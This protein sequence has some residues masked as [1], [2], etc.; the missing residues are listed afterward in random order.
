M[1]RRLSLGASILGERHGEDLYT[2]ATAVRARLLRELAATF[3]DVDVLVSPA[4]LTT[5][6]LLGTQPPP[7]PAAPGDSAFVRAVVPSLPANYRDDEFT[8]F[9]SLVRPPPSSS[10][11]HP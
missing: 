1:R 6:R 8:C 7:S 10:L 2:R 5:A 4:A 3:E 9:A 11:T